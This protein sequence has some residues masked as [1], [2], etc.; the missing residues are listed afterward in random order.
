MTAP[1]KLSSRLE[2]IHPSIT[3][4]VTAKAARLRAGGADIVS[5][6]AGEPDFETP[7]HIREAARRALDTGCSKYTEVGGLLALR[8][9]CAAELKRAHGLELSPEQILVSTGAK[10]SLYN[11]FMAML[12]DGDE[13]VIPAPY[14]VSYPDMV[15]LAGGEPVIVPTRADD[16]FQLD[17]RDLAA[18][19]TPRTRA[20][21][22][23]T[24]SNPTGALYTRERLQA[25]ADVC[26][27][28]ELW[29]ISDDIY[30]ALVYGDRTY[31]SI[32]SLSPDIARR[33]ILVDGVSKAYAMTGWRIGYTA[34]PEPL[35]RAMGK[36]QGQS[37]SNPTHIAQLAALA[38]LT[39]PQ[40]CVGEMRAA[41]NERRL[42]MVE[43]LRAIS[44]VTCVEPLGAFYA[45]PDVSAYVGRRTQKGV[46]INDDVALCE[47]LLEA[48]RVAVVPGSGFGAPGYVRLS[49]ATSMPEITRGIVRIGEALGGLG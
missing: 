45:F 30:R 2:R 15:K 46:A 44:G 34:G 17:A 3:M 8:Q 21:V 33:T 16:G 4:A 9:A 32:A 12:D 11:I 35:I 13:V 25:L 29:V 47:Y 37:T 19:I 40:D 20:V 7:A 5:F 49:Y 38:A 28:R 48:G 26:I 22:L 10:H 36:L 23:N 6:G 27:E 1:L 39:G 43:G 24:P 14:W 18:A 41:F 42:T 31:V